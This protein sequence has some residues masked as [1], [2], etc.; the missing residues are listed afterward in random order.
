[1]NERSWK[2]LVPSTQKLSLRRIRENNPVPKGKVDGQQENIIIANNVVDEILLHRKQ[3]GSATKE[4]AEF[5]YS[6]Y[7]ENEIYQVEREIIE[8]TVEKLK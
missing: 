5:V 1:M 2:T 4:A 6:D 3:K 7:D 8:E